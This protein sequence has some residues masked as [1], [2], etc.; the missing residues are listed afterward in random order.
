MVVHILKNK[1]SVVCQ[2]NIVYINSKPYAHY[3]HE[4]VWLVNVPRIIG[5]ISNEPNRYTAKLN[6]E[7]SKKYVLKTFEKEIFE[8]HTK[9]KIAISDN[10][11]FD[12]LAAVLA[13]R[14]YTLMQERSK[15]ESRQKQTT[16][17][18]NASTPKTITRQTLQKTSQEKPKEFKVVQS[19]KPK[20][21]KIR[22]EPKPEKLKIEKTQFEKHKPER[23]REEFKQEGNRREE[24]RYEEPPR[25][26][27]NIP[28]PT[29]G[30]S[31]DGGGG[32]AGCIWI[33]ILL[34]CI[35]VAISM[36][37]QSW[38]DLGEYIPKGDTGI[39]ICFFSSLIGGITAIAISFLKKTPDFSYCMTWFFRCCVA[40][41]VINTI[42]LLA[43]G[44]EFTGFFLFDIP[45]SFFAPILGCFQFA[46]PIGIVAAIVSGIVCLA[47]K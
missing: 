42:S 41:I 45:L 27:P 7:P 34:L 1:E 6:L 10:M 25:E 19:Q 32:Y 24:K 5:H 33:P 9:E 22:V 2:K 8:E 16:P 46:L 31:E 21:E 28:L 23:K 17:K 47:R 18:V 29:G 26:L 12:S 13:Y 30:S 35:G 39:T 3:S 4:M 11:N 15:V 40:G 36:I 37:P 43:E 44:V 38:R 14:H 20:P